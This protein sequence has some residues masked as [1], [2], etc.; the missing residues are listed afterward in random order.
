[1]Q[2]FAGYTFQRIILMFL[3]LHC[4]SSCMKTY[5]IV[6]FLLMLTVF[7]KQTFEVF[8]YHQAFT[9]NPCFA[10]LV[11]FY[12]S[13]L[14]RAHSLRHFLPK[15]NSSGIIKTQNWCRCSDFP[16]VEKI[17]H[18]VHSLKAGTGFNRSVTVF[19]FQDTISDHRISTEA[20][21]PRSRTNCLAVS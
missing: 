20:R 17:G 16:H 11:W 14:A 3:A 1:M 19:D 8:V 13:H 2:S 10:R 9:S 5:S 18:V 7:V 21:D 6:F 4:L 12:I 15:R